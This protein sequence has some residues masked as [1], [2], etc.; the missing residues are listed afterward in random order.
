[1]ANDRPMTPKPPAGL[2]PLTRQWF[3]DT[4]AR[5]VLEDHHRSIFSKA[6]EREKLFEHPMRS[7]NA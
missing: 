4:C 2:R 1:M 3:L 6:V 7:S 5:W